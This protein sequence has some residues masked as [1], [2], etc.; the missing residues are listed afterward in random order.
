MRKIFS[1]F[2][3]LFSLFVFSAYAYA[4]YQ[5]SPNLVTDVLL[6]LPF[7]SIWLTPLLFWFGEKAEMKPWAHTF[8]M[9]SYFSMGFLNFL[10]VALIPLNLATLVLELAGSKS[11]AATLDRLTMP[12]T[13]AIAVLCLVVGYIRA[14]K[15][16]SIRELTIPLEAIGPSSALNALKIVQISD[17]H[18]G[19]TIRKN[20][21]DHVVRKSNALN[22][23]LIVLTGDIVDGSLKDL[24]DQAAPLKDLTAKLGVYLILGNHDY[25]SGAKVWV[26]EFESMGIKVLLNSHVRISKD[27]EEF[28][29]AGVLDPAV[30]GFSPE[31]K[32]DPIL[33]LGKP[34]LSSTILR[35]LLAHN[36]KLAAEAQRAGFHLQLSGHTHAGQFIPWTW[37]TKL[38]HKPHYVGLSEEGPMK[39]FVSA[40][41]GSWGPPIRLGTSPEISSLTLAA[42]SF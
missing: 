34:E 27:G 17:L 6:A 13:F 23:D 3:L 4:R 19:P 7:L 16:P 31:E 22:P 12:L 39:V 2:M 18:V 41:T 37:V 38:V 11:S 33:A 10:F 9:F 15:G 26:K 29:L 36:P 35:I 21:V 40:G 28:L 24:R 14:T 1:P 30:Q 5:L 25:Y 8:Q 20:Y 42:K 32:P